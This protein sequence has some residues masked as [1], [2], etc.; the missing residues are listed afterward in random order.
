M[1]AVKELKLYKI[2]LALFGIVI[3]GCTN[4][5]KK[6]LEANMFSSNFYIY[7]E[8][9]EDTY[10][11]CSTVPIEVEYRY[12]VGKWKY[13]DNKGQLIAEGLYKPKKIKIE[14]IGGCPYEM[15]EG[16]IDR[17]TWKFWD[18]KGA[19]ISPSDGLIKR[20]ENCKIVKGIAEQMKKK[21]SEEHGL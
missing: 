18:R 1:K 16:K 7:G 6:P 15:K 8:Y 19:E 5:E 17:E 4:T 21:N 13:W 11:F 9:K 3:L 12:K 14:G 20:I 2:K 10:S